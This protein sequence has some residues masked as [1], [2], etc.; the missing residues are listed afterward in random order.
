MSALLVEVRGILYFTFREL[1]D[2]KGIK[3]AVIFNCCWVGAPSCIYYIE[4][5]VA[6]D[7]LKLVFICVR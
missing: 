5:G 6:Y 7:E 3:S 1:Y 2:V 4:N